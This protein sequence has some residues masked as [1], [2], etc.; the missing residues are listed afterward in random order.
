MFSLDDRKKIDTLIL[1]LIL[2]V[3]GGYTRYSMPGIECEQQDRVLFE[4][5]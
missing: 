3:P 2:K 5:A 1:G 4:V